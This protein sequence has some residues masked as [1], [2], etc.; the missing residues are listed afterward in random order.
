LLP[1]IPELWS[2]IETEYLNLRI[3]LSITI[4]DIYYRYNLKKIVPISFT[5]LRDYAKAEDPKSGG[6]SCQRPGPTARR[7][8]AKSRFPVYRAFP[9]ITPVIPTTSKES[10]LN[11]SVKELT[12]PDA[13]TGILT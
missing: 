4:L 11:K 1:I 9:I 13:M 2:T 6:T 7:A 8:S 10:K 3:L 5:Q 12:P